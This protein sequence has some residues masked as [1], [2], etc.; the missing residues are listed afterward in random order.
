MPKSKNREASDMSQQVTSS[1]GLLAAARTVSSVAAKHSSDANENRRLSPE[2]VEAIAAA[3]FMRHFVPVEMGGAAAGFGEFTQAAGIVA[4]GCASAAWVAGVSAAVGRMTAF[5]PKRG[6]QEVWS[7]GPDALVVGALMPFG[8]ASAVDG[9][10][11][12]TGEW[13]YISAVDFSDWAL[14]CG[15]VAGGGQP[16]QRYFAVPRRAYSIVD[17]WFNTGM[18]GTGSNTLVLT[19][20]FV[21]EWCSVPRANVALGRHSESPAICHSVPLNSVNGLPFGASALGAVRGMLTAWSTATTQKINAGVTGAGRP[22]VSRASFDELLAR[23]A[24]EV[25][26]AEMLFERAA[27]TAERGQLSSLEAARSARDCSLAIGHLVDAA[28]RMLRAGGTGAHAE[29]SP[30]GRAWRDTN[31][32]ASHLALRLELTAAGY[33]DEVLKVAKENEES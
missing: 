32:A 4:E 11:Q 17:T 19:D 16:E 14:V 33:A 30:V 8:R 2:V 29:N 26:V 21:P 23:T 1:S 3:G 7:E 15:L 25:D 18:R 20:V 27:G 24:G 31:T 28:N 6:W 12:L 9:G 5:L 22:A 13:P 10:W